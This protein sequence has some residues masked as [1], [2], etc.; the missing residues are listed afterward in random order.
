MKKEILYKGKWVDFVNFNGYEVLDENKSL[1]III[2]LIINNHENS[3]HHIHIGI[4]SEFCPPYQMFDGLERNWY[5]VISGGIEKD[6]TRNEALF[7]ELYEEAGLKFSDKNKVQLQVI[8][9][10]IPLCKSAT[11]RA[12]IILLKSESENV[13]FGTPSG[14]GTEN[15]KKSKTL[16]VN[17]IELRDIVKNKNCDLLLNYANLVIG[18]L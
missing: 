9:D 8:N 13:T 3:A 17:P 6:E 1:V 15:E 2:P 7:R 4:R 11:L 14:D 5:T 12:S 18:G 16:W 10:N